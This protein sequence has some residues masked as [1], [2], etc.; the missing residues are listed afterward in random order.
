MSNQDR[1]WRW[2]GYA[3]ETEIDKLIDFE[4]S[5][6][7]YFRRKKSVLNHLG[8]GNSINDILRMDMNMVLPDDMLVKVDMMSMA[9][10]LEVRVPFLD[11]RVVDFA[12]SL[13]ESYKIDKNSSKKIL[14]E[15]FRSEL[16]PEL[17][18]R[19]KHGFEV[20]LLKWFRT[21]LRHLIEKELLSEEFIEH[22]GLFNYAGIDNLKR[23]L[24]SSTPGDIEGRM[25]GLIVFQ[26][27]WRKF[28][29]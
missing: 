4:Y 28:M 25:W 8:N 20:P 18:T 9:N 6:N 16:P 22:Q 11:Y 7:D 2:C 1:Y 3:G 10:S 12:F 23:K 17:F 24:F 5:N 27:W 19:A 14:R 26:Y 29:D 13:P 21:E 15:S